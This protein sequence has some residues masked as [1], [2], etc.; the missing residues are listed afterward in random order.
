ML[1]RAEYY[2]LLASKIT[3]E[4]IICTIAGE[5]RDWGIV[6]ERDGNL[7]QVYMSGTTSVALGVAL[8]LPHRRVIALD[9]DGSILMGL[10]VLPVVAQQNP[11]NLIII[12]FDNEAYEAAGKIPTFTA[13][14]TDLVEVARGAGIRN[15]VTVRKLSEFQKAIDE[16]F[17]A[18]GATFMVVKTQLG[19]LPGTWVA[20]DGTE[21]KYR[22]I[23]YI[24]RTEKLQ[25]IK[26]A[27][28]KVWTT[29]KV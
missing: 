23:R 19:F 5:A 27:K 24:E 2:K 21:N 25:I 16:A 7:Y 10:T 15:V 22:F 29:D 13:G 28:K 4:L 18:N 11:S 6:K 3:D 9:G 20:M 14:P 1:S 8:A 17:Q 26:P 12:V